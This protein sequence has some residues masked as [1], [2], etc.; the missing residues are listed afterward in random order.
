MEIQ[1]Y[2][3]KLEKFILGLDNNSKAKVARTINLL[4]KFGPAIGMPHS[5]PI[6]KGIFELR[7]RGKQEIRIFYLFRNNTAILLHGYIKKSF[8]IPANELKAVFEKIK[9]LE[10]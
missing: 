10:K 1:I 9:T 6:A 3:K 5:K 8:R 7:I 4:E 2:D